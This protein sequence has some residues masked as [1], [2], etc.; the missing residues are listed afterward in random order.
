MGIIL[1]IWIRR[2]ASGHI[3]TVKEFIK[4]IDDF[5]EY[6][7]PLKQLGGIEKTERKGITVYHTSISPDRTKKYVWEWEYWGGRY[8]KQTIIQTRKINIY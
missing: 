6:S 7:K 4:D 8:G 1:K 2:A 3:I 5:M